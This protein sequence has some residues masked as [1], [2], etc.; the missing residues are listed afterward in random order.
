MKKM[1]KVFLALFVGISCLNV[2]SSSV[3]ATNEEIPA[4]DWNKVT[5]IEIKD[6]GEGKARSNQTTKIIDTPE[7]IQAFR[8]ELE[9]V[10]NDVPKSR[11]THRWYHY[12]TV[13][14]HLKDGYSGF[15][16]IYDQAISRC[17]SCG[18][19]THG[20]RRYLTRHWHP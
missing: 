17:S 2:F 19:L 20:P 7:E 15:C 8:E 16:Y 4:F 14:Y 3:K 12:Y 6:A 18:Q 5:M 13:V 1:T 10:E 9:G 11:H